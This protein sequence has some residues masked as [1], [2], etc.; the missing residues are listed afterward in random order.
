MNKPTLLPQDFPLFPDPAT[1]SSSLRPDSRWS[2]S[3]SPAYSPSPAWLFSVPQEA[4]ER[5]QHDDS[6]SS[7]SSDDSSSYSE[8]STDYSS[9]IISDPASRPS[10]LN[11]ED[12]EDEDGYTPNGQRLVV[13]RDPR[14]G[15]VLHL[16]FEYDLEAAYD[17]F[18][19]QPLVQVP[20]RCWWCLRAHGRGR[21][22]EGPGLD[23]SARAVLAVRVA[24]CLLLAVVL[25]GIFEWK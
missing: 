17:D 3:S 18:A 13:Y 2:S 1:M 19:A 15:S 23:R 6:S 12:D 10:S 22:L 9:T 20:C 7:D 21:E 16:A 4:F 11:D 5:R 8:S 25:V 14:D 24:V